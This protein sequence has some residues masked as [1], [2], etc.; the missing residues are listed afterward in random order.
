METLLDSQTSRP[1][2]TRH[3]AGPALTVRRRRPV[4]THEGS[5]P[6]IEKP[7]STD[8][9]RLLRQMENS[10]TERE[11]A[12]SEAEAKLAERT[13]DMDEME[14]L[15]R[16]R[17]ALLVASRLRRPTQQKTITPREAVALEEL[18]AELERQEKSIREA[19]EALREREAFL[20][21]SE[22]RLFAKVQEQQ[23]KE[24]EL[25]QR[26]EELQTRQRTLDGSASPFAAAA[27]KRFDEF[28]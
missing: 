7:L 8:A 2:P 13:R 23:E 5:N 15:L 27:P 10:L 1:F 26:E 6:P 28:R 9:E 18:K 22:T 17:E 4:A 11:R 21:E 3:P 24:T 20:T 25:E 16:A 19:R 12:V 14:A